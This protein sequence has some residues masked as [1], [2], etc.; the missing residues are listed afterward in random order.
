MTP[1]SALPP[2]VNSKP[3]RKDC[4]SRPVCTVDAARRIVE[5]AAPSVI[6]F[7]QTSLIPEGEGPLGKVPPPELC[8]FV[9]GHSRAGCS[10][11]RGR[12]AI[13][14]GLL[15]EAGAADF[16]ER[17]GGCLPI[18]LEKV[19]RRLRHAQ[20][21]GSDAQQLNAG[22][23][24]MNGEAFGELLRHEMNNPLT[25]NPGQRGAASRGGAPQK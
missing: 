3:K 16:V 22:K 19:E 6:L 1:S 15:V 5:D 20:Q 24:V 12:A 10:H 13:G 2:A 11:W 8:G 25:G 14:A 7:E 9:A 4:A 17:A 18:A 21:T 23:N